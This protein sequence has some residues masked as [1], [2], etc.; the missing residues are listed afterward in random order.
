MTTLTEQLNLVASQIKDIEAAKR[1][2][3]K[4]MYLTKKEAAALSDARESMKA[5]STY[6]LLK[7]SMDT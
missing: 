2:T 5:L 4:S 1:A 6:A 3:E 7:P